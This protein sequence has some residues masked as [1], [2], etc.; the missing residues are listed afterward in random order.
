MQRNQL[1]HNCSYS[2]IYV[3]PANWK[4]AKSNDLNKKWFI[5]YIFFDPKHSI[6]YPK[7]KTLRIRAQRFETIDERRLFIK[8]TVE[9]IHYNLN[10]LCYNPIDEKCYHQNSLNVRIEV[11]HPVSGLANGQI[12]LFPENPSRN[13]NYYLNDQNI[14]TANGVI[15]NLSPGDY[16]I[17]VIA[18]NGDIFI[19][20]V[21]LEISEKYDIQGNLPCIHAFRLATEKLKISDKYKKDIR[22]VVNRLEPMFEKQGYADIPINNLTRSQLKRVLEALELSPIYF[23][24]VKASLSSI[25]NELVQYECCEINITRD[26]AK[27]KETKLVR[28]T[29][30]DDELLNIKNY[31][32]EKHYTF[33]RYMMIFFYSGARTSELLRLKAKD[34]SLEK[35]EFKVYILKG[36]GKYQEVVKVI[37][38]AVIPMWKNILE[39]V[40][41]PEEYLFAKNLQ[42][43][44]SP[45]TPIQISRRWRIRV[46]DIIKVDADFYSLKHL[47]LDK[48][49]E[50]DQR[51]QTNIFNDSKLDDNIASAH[52]SHTSPNITNSV[53][54]VNKTKRIQQKLKLMTLTV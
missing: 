35:Q 4:T 28:K 42:P 26:I 7:G 29:L 3:S 6:K 17:K 22:I 49:D 51:H 48:L 11:S 20:D 19:E 43:G 9:Q 52:A 44:L 46:K 38:P 39:E 31:L 34:V 1:A 30:T 37:L 32:K 2:N 18:E 53:Y 10:T 23:N 12:K 16:Q 45:I 14:I 5:E 25:F 54:L 36:S 41:D 15:S 24:R 8:Q 47:F 27:K 33:Y 40:K 50:F 13:Y 21:V